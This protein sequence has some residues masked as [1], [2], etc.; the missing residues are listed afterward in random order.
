MCLIMMTTPRT[1]PIIQRRTQPNNPPDSRP[2]H[3]QLI[4]E[5]NLH[6]IPP[7]RRQISPHCH[8]QTNLPN[9]QTTKSPTTYPTRKPTFNPSNAPTDKPTLSPTNKHTGTKPPTPNPTSNPTVR[10]SKSPTADPTMRPTDSPTDP[11]DSI[12][13]PSAR[14]NGKSIG[15]SSKQ[16]TQSVNPMPHGSIIELKKQNMIQLYNYHPPQDSSYTESDLYDMVAKFEKQKLFTDGKYQLIIITDLQNHV[17]QKA[18][19]SLQATNNKKLYESNTVL[20]KTLSAILSMTNAF[21]QQSLNEAMLTSNWAVSILWM[22]H[23][24]DSIY[25]GIRRELYAEWTPNKDNPMEMDCHDFLTHNYDT[26][27][28]EVHS[29]RLNPRRSILYLSTIDDILLNIL[30]QYTSISLVHL[31]RAKLIELKVLCVNSTY[32]KHGKIPTKYRSLIHELERR[33]VNITTQYVPYYFNTSRYLHQVQGL[34]SDAMQRDPSLVMLVVSFQHARLRVDTFMRDL[35]K[36]A[37]GLQISRIIYDWKQANKKDNHG[38]IAVSGGCVGYMSC[39]QMNDLL[40]NIGYVGAA[41]KTL[42]VSSIRKRFIVQQD[43]TTHTTKKQQSE[44]TSSMIKNLT[45]INQ[46]D[47]FFFF[48]SRL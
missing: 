2:N 13:I 47:F 21:A 44:I 23:L 39:Y 34:S 12:A 15:K 37:Y 5:E 9:Y 28:E 30:H 22:C 8:Q 1:R 11:W 40:N 33:A 10:P 41:I 14:R 25:D 24:P 35:F 4:Q 38:I 27:R 6:L 48:F 7:M 45:V 43:N 18:I 36:V 17:N 26:L 3:L 29:N 46:V 32:G 31:I 16:Q 20:D 19:S 42:N